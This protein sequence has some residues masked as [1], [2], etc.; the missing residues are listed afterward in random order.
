MHIRLR[1]TEGIFDPTPEKAVAAK[2]AVTEE[3]VEEKQEEV[4]EEDIATTSDDTL[5]TEENVRE[6]TTEE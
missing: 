6:D 4:V 1:K 2:A 3:P 5:D